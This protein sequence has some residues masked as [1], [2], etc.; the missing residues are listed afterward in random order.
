M[1]AL[2]H[3]AMV[4][5]RLA[6]LRFL[7]SNAPMKH[8]STISK[9]PVSRTIIRCITRMMVGSGVDLGGDGQMGRSKRYQQSKLANCVFT[10][11]LKVCEPS[12]CCMH[13]QHEGRIHTCIC[14]PMP[15]LLTVCSQIMAS[16]NPRW[17]L[18]L[19]LHVAASKYL[20][21]SGAPEANVLLHDA[22]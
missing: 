15:C 11:A 5:S 22:R 13:L 18:K 4:L 8:R 14:L 12:R 16:V 6:R 2:I 17:R 21:C 9:V 1:V 19:L 7:C 10:L 3:Y 20:F